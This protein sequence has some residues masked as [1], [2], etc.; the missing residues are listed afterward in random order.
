MKSDWIKVLIAAVFEVLWVI[1]LKHADSLWSW[2]GTL[3]AI[4]ISFYGLIA[5]GRRLP[6][7]TVYATFVGLGSA[8]TVLSEMF[9]F[10]EPFELAKL[11][12]ILLLLIGVIGLKQ[13]TPSA[14]EEGRNS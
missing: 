14:P 1:G 4:L 6:V 7:G 12:L 3:L 5:A 10:G 8:G 9:F 11:L 2:A 13:V